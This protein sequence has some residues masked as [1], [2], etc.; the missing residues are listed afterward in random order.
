ML[1]LQIGKTEN[2]IKKR[3]LSPSILVEIQLVSIRENQ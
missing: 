2:Q 1:F 3:E